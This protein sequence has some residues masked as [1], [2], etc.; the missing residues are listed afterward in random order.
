MFVKVYISLQSAEI[1]FENRNMIL[2]LQNVHR[3]LRIVKIE[4]KKM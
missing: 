1:C 2:K 3:K 4:S